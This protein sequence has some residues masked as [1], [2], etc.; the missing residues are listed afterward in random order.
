MELEKT[1]IE[2]SEEFT[3]DTL[4]YFKVV[5]YN[6]DWHTFEEVIYQLIKAIGCSF[7]KAKK[8]TLEVHF[9]GKSVVY[10]GK[11]NTC[12]KVSSILEEI[13]LHTQILC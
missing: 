2:I 6:D 10:F 12:L 7:E 3:S 4:D 13:E 8:L 9:Q 1:K 5:L 11:L